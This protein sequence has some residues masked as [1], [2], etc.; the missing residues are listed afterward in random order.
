MAYANW[1]GIALDRTAVYLDQSEFMYGIALDITGLSFPFYVGGSIIPPSGMPEDNNMETYQGLRVTDRWY[2]VRLVDFLTRGTPVTGILFGNVIVGYG[3][4]G[5][6]AETNMPVLVGD[7]KEQ[8]GGDYWLRMGSAEFANFG[9]Y[10]IRVSST[11]VG[12]F[13]DRSFVVEVLN[14][15]LVLDSALASHTTLGTLGQRLQAI[16]TGTAQSGALGTIQLDAGASAINDFYKGATILI[17]VGLGLYQARTITGYVGGTQQAT[18]EP[19]WVTTPNNTSEFVI[20]PSGESL[21]APLAIDNAWNEL[22]TGHDVVNSFGQM[23]NNVRA[24]VA[25]GGAPGTITLDVG[26]SAVNDFYNGNIIFISKGLGIGQARI[27]SAYDGVTK[28]ATISPNWIVNPGAL[29]EYVI[30]PTSAV[31]LSA[32]AIINGILDADLQ[33]HLGAGVGFR[34]IGNML[35][36]LAQSEFELRTN[37]FAAGAVVAQ[38]ITA[39]MAAS[40]CIQYQRV[41]MS[42]TKT[43]G[44]PDRTYYLLWHYDANRRNDIVKASIGTIW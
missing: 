30:I 11:P 22:T 2:S 13:A 25:T 1:I 15:E 6:A 16:R 33:L 17:T 44:A 31:S 12:I 18:I 36:Q 40:G 21:L 3:F 35:G 28:I 29:S 43:W 26:A 9:K 10:T 27:I 5:D 8:G 4:E 20:I 34:N 14:P 42:Y 38:G 24:S 37:V 32:T 19:N 23:L 7:W 41:D 39:A